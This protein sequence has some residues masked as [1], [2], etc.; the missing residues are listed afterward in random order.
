MD[1]GAW[2]NNDRIPYVLRI[3]GCEFGLTGADLCEIREHIDN[4]LKGHLES[5]SEDCRDLRIQKRNQM[6][7]VDLVK[8]LGIPT[9]PKPTFVLEGFVRRV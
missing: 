4:I 2:T 3:R 8:R 1:C 9:K 7:G 6:R 5:I